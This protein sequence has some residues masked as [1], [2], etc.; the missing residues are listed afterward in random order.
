MF[1]L[2]ILSLQDIVRNRTASM[3]ASSSE[4]A[5]QS[6]VAP[7]V[8]AVIWPVEK[9]D[10]KSVEAIYLAVC[11]GPWKT[12]QWCLTR[13]S[14]RSEKR[15]LRRGH[16][17]GLQADNHTG[18]CTVAT[19]SVPRL[20]SLHTPC[21]SRRKKP[22]TH[23]EMCLANFGFKKVSPHTS[24]WKSISQKVSPHTSN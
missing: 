6:T 7:K 20:R 5:P 18:I 8:L 2:R 11:K 14:N 13:H 12:S 10:K 9:I 24:N 19:T 3:A 15:C 23:S 17:Q 1:H 21:T 16:G 22:S 4:D